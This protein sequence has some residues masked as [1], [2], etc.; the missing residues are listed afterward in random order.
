MPEKYGDC[1]VDDAKHDAVKPQAVSDPCVHIRLRPK[2]ANPRLKPSIRQHSAIAGSAAFGWF[3]QDRLM[4][5]RVSVCGLF[6]FQRLHDPL[7]LDPFARLLILPELQHHC[8]KP[9]FVWDKP[10]LP[11]G[12]E[13]AAVWNL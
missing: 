13:P 1:E 10:H 6:Q 8:E 11:P 3:G 9:P 2:S 4:C 5:S 7:E 12:R